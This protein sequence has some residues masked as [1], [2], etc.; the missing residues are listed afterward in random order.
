MLASLALGSSVVADCD[1]QVPGI[2]FK[3]AVQKS[4]KQFVAVLAEVKRIA[5]QVWSFSQRL[6][7]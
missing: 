5:E 4:L 2:S 1:L 6:E 3:P 7:Q